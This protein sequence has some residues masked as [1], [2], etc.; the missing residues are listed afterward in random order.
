MPQILNAS[1]EFNLETE[2]T[3][4]ISYTIIDRYKIFE[5]NQNQNFKV[6]L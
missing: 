6:N 5:L 2:N 4:M 3:L 1:F